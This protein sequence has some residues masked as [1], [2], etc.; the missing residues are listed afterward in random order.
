MA[1]PYVALLKD[2]RI[3]V[4]WIGLATSAIGGQL[5]GVGALWLAAELAGPNAALLVTAQSA[6]ILAVSILGGPVV[7]AL[8]R[9]GFLVGV[10]LVSAA[11]CAVVVAASTMSGLSFPLL[12]TVSVVLAA[13]GAA[14]RPVFLSSLPTLAPASELRAANGLFDGTV[15]VAQASGPFLAA[16]IL[17]VLPAI[18]LLTANAASF[19]ASAWA[20]AAVG[21]G[22]DAPRAAAPT[23]G[24]FRRLARGV[25]AANGCRGVWSALVT[26]AIRGGSYALGFTVAV[27][28]IFAE[29]DGAG[30]LAGVAVVFGAAAASELLAGPLVVLTDPRRP[31]RRQFEG[32]LLVG[33]AQALVG[34]GAMFP[35]PARIPAMAA[36][37]LAMGV[38]HSIAGLQMLT[39]FSSRLSSDDY[40]AVLRLRLVLVIA[41]MMAATAAGPLILPLLGAAQTAIA[42]GL[43]AA[44]AAVVS[45]LGK[46]ARE[47]GPGF[48]PPPA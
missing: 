25:H 7:E 42:C 22:L 26:T 3:R 47:L 1:H 9:R 12:V 27:P 41:A 13:M 19:V 37:A 45:A 46:P 5:F 4:L 2:R 30:G 44:A 6:A 43:V 23:T 8:P 21:R 14:H 16:A 48:L 35:P 40:A 34:A 10:D 31:L 39:F 28:L 11:A 33:V 32:Y 38:G 24:L 18:H 20:V 29:G 17:A 36:A 15:R